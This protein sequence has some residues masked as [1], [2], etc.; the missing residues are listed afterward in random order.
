MFVFLRII[1]TKLPC[2]SLLDDKTS[3]KLYTCDIGIQIKVLSVCTA[4]LLYFVMYHTA[5]PII[6]LRLR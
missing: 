5:L 3:Y 1:E 4:V 6:V 2:G